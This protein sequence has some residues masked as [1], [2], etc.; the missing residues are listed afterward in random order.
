MFKRMT[1]ILLV[2]AALVVLVAGFFY[3]RKATVKDS[4]PFMAIAMDAA[5]VGRVNS[6]TGLLAAMKTE[7]GFWRELGIVMNSHRFAPAVTYLDSVFSSGTV[8]GE[9]FGSKNLYFSMHPSAK[10]NYDVIFY[11]PLSTSRNSRVYNDAMK[12]HLNG[13]ALIRERLYGRVT[14]YDADFRRDSGLRNL[15]WA[16]HDGIFI[17]SFSPLLLENA[18]SQLGSTENLLNDEAFQRVLST[19][20]RN[21]EANILFNLNILPGY[22]STFAKGPGKEMLSGI[23]PLGNW[24]EL[25]L[26]LRDNAILLNGFSFSDDSPGN[27]LNI[28]KDQTPEPSGI[29]SVLPGY[30]S[31]FLALNLSNIP[32]FHK[33]Y[34]SWMA[35][36]GKLVRYNEMKDEFKHLTGTYPETAFHSF[37]EGEVAL[38]LANREETADE[39]SFI[40][41]KTKSQSQTLGVMLGMI[42]HNA[43][44][45]GNVLSSYKSVYH[46]D[47]ETPFDIYHFPFSNTGGLLFGDV[48]SACHTSYFCFVDNYLVFGKSAAGLSEFIHS[49]VLNQT[50][51][52]N[53]HFREFS[54][55]LVSRNNLYFYS[56]VANSEKL[57]TSLLN[58]RL[59]D[60]LLNNH[61]S[62]RKFQAFSLQLS[63]GRDMIYNNVFIRFSPQVTERSHTRWQTLLD[64]VADFKPYLLLNHITGERDIFVQDINHTI[65]LINQAGRI[66]WKKPLTGKIM[67]NIH[68]IDYYNNNRF[69]LMFNTREQIFLVDRNGND[70]DRYPIRLPSP[71]TNGISVF[72]YENN[73]DYR[74]FVACED[75]SVVVRSKNG[76]VIDGWNFRGTEHHVRQEIRYFRIEGRD[77]IVFADR[78]RVY[79]LDR[80]GNTRAIPDRTFPVST[81]NETAFEG[82][83]SSSDPRIVLTDTSGG[84]WHVY[85]NGKTEN[86]KFGS[87]SPGHFFEFQDVNA[88]GYKDYIYIDN[89]ILDVFDHNGSRM[90]RHE[91]PTAITHGPSYY[92]F[93]ARD[94]KLGITAS[95][96]GQIYLFNSNGELY[97]GFPMSGI[98]QFTIGQLQTDQGNFQLLVGSNNN[99]LYNYTV[100]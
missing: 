29:E 26:H 21:V 48:F 69:Q 34:L 37:M 15:S 9:L 10:E 77:F 76:N 3:M 78:H 87:F 38:V 13:H 90:F 61:E 68:Q 17:L 28:F 39:N 59:S 49:N 27:Y 14:V 97:D 5:V 11:M 43:V 33:N 85:F 83:T 31:A 6:F 72:D 89:N 30:A 84:V 60:N 46:V 55:Y 86:L 57:F 35:E 36:T 65:Y 47:R 79:M 73:K 91:F 67:G 93:S 42:G 16:T 4:D 71:A 54:E 56:N 45:T 62:F 7:S 51:S 22:L 24:A 92:Y 80:R 74:L 98:S 88:N 82:R 75:K 70:V 2:V 44:L 12:E 81:R 23:G 63:S 64:T 8:A 95:D 20:G 1:L 40:V 53:P 18:V 94:R 19:S 52:S 66:L 99:F 50:L 32:V 96:Q 41:I 58:D 25:D 100:Y